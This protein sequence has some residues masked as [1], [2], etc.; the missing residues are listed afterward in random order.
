M[1]AYFSYGWEPILSPNCLPVDWITLVRQHLSLEEIQ[2]IHSDPTRLIGLRHDCKETS[3]IL[4]DIDHSSNYRKIDLVRE[5]CRLMCHIGLCFPIF[6]QSSNKGD[7]YKGIHIYWFL[8]KRY[9]T[10]LL[11]ELV[12]ILLESYNFIPSA[13]N[14]EIFPNESNGVNYKCKPV[15]LPLQPNSGSYILDENLQPY[16]D[17]IDELSRLILISF[18]TPNFSTLELDRKPHEIVPSDKAK[19]W[20]RDVDALLRRGFTTTA[21]SQQLIRAAID[22]VIVFEKI[23]D[24]DIICD[25]VK[26]IVV[27]LNGY[28][29]YCGHQRNID[30]VIKT[31]VTQTLKKEVRAPYHKKIK[32]TMSGKNLISDDSIKN[33]LENFL[34][35]KSNDTLTRLVACIDWLV[36]NQEVKFSTLLSFRVRINEISHFLY[37]KGIS[38]KIVQAQRALW[39][40][41]IH[42][43]KK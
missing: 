2:K 42:V 5:I 20:L 12:R 4:L 25:K 7:Y 1:F 19:Q 39:E 30:K 36:Q 31:W 29:Q 26:F 21:Q 40:A 13:G 37:G 22:K 27:N 8:D 43:G 34:R 10:S 41:R 9:N 35:C 33:N 11:A 15:R 17:S 14:L 18:N 28:T 23:T 38:P 3:Y 6:I 16:T 24:L 32:E